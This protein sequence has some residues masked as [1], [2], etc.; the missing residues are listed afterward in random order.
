M[1]NG[2]QDT[3]A[4]DG[5]GCIRGGYTGLVSKGCLDGHSLWGEVMLSLLSY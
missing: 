4:R 2:S 3:L 5:A 1:Q